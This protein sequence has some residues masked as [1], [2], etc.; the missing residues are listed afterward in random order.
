MI[1]YTETQVTFSE[2]PDEISLCINISNCHHKCSGCHSPH[3]QEDVGEE[4]TVDKLQELIDKNKGITCVCFMGGDNDLSR[5]S[6][7]ADIAH[8]FD[9]CG[10]TNK[11]KTAWYTGLDFHLNSM[12]EIAD[13]P[14]AQKF[15]YVKTGSYIEALGPLNKKTTNQ[16]M[17]KK[18][19]DKPVK[20]EDITYKFQKGENND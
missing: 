15:D 20:F 2:I 10:G 12:Q 6:E 16:R 8:Q 18:V 19:S 9:V 1:K 4:L 17:Y 7:L 14:I 11:I 13:R 5:L 3:L